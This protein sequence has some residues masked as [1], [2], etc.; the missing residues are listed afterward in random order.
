MAGEYLTDN[1]I[2]GNGEVPAIRGK[3]G[4]EWVL[5]G[6]L[7]TRSRELAQ[8]YAERLNEIITANLSRYR[9]RLFS[10]KR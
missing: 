4:I 6:G 1:I 2:V 8:E 10:T 9:R 7:R 3:Y 5:P